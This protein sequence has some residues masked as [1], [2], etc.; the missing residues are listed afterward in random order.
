MHPYS[1]TKIRPLRLLAVTLRALASVVRL[2]PLALIGLFVLSPVGPHMRW[3]YTYHEYGLHRVYTAC[4]YLGSSGFVEY[5]DR[6]GNCPF[7]TVIDRR[8]IR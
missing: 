8:V 2:W 4:E 1:P 6:E 5:M 3:Q 7:F